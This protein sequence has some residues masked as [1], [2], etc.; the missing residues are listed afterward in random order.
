MKKLQRSVTSAAAF[1][2]FK[3]TLAKY[4]AREKAKGTGPQH[5]KQWSTFA[6]QWL[7]WDRKRNRL[8]PHEIMFPGLENLPR[9][10]QE[11]MQTARK[12]LGDAGYFSSNKDP[13]GDLAPARPMSSASRAGYFALPVGA[14]VGGAALLNGA[15]GEGGGQAQ[16]APARQVNPALAPAAR[17]SRQPPAPHAGI[18]SFHQ[19]VVEHAKA[20]G[21]TPLSVLRKIFYGENP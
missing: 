14:G 15:P 3:T 12:E 4:L 11:Q 19:S 6:N 8:E 21:K 5:H 1:E 9:M 17:Y 20:S 7:L 2:A 18:D 13:E 16:A 10:S